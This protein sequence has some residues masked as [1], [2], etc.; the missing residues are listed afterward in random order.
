MEQWLDGLTGWLGANPQWLGVAIFLVACIECLAIAGIIVP[1][2]VLLFAVAV[3]AG[4]GVL[5]LGETLLLGF[6]GGLL[7]DAL[8]YMIGKHFHQN[9]RR[10]PVLRHHPEWIGSAETYFK[11]YGIAS[12]LVG[13]FI[14]PLRPMLPM[15]AGMFDMPL[16]R[17]VAVSLVA[18]AGWSIAYLLPG[19]ATGAAMRLPLPEGFWPQAGIIFGTLAVIIGLSL[20]TSIRDR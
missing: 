12:L 13:R 4:S 11:R 5:G 8:S 6:L 20:S 14:G 9:I 10:L 15:V 16:L 7:G 2:T 3:L 19:W 18:A 17:F 1:G